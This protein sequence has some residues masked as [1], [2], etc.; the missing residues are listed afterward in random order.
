MGRPS[1]TT[2]NCPLRARL[3]PLSS[4]PPSPPFWYSFARWTTK[5]TTTTT[6]S[7]M[8]TRLPRP[9]CEPVLNALCSELELT[10]SFLPSLVRMLLPSSC[11]SVPPPTTT[12]AGFLAPVDDDDPFATLAGGVDVV[13]VDA[14]STSTVNGAQQGDQQAA[15][16]DE[17]DDEEE[18]EESDSDD[19]RSIL[20]SL[21][22]KVGESSPFVSFPSLGPRDRPRP[23]SWTSP[24]PQVSLS[25]FPLLLVHRPKSSP[26][27]GTH[28]R[29]RPLS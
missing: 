14:P 29:P 23:Y 11:R 17:E 20:S 2:R 26:F 21:L 8:K 13:H 15:D 10:F 27:T 5:P 9:Q 25:S 28:P 12:D 18:E 22:L 19:V 24:R 3:L 16:D 7:S 4:I 1:L 6:P